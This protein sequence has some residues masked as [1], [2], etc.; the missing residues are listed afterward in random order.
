MLLMQ[1][2]DHLVLVLDVLLDLLDVFGHL[3]VV[4]FLEVVHGL[5]DFLGRGQDVLDGVGHDKVLVAFEAVDWAL[6]GTGH[7]LFLVAAVV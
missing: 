4:F 6:F 2:L 1:I 7:G 5:W 3:T